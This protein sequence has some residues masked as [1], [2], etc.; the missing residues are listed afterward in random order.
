MRE[1]ELSFDDVF[2]KGLR[3]EVSPVNAPVMAELKNAKPG[4]FGL[5]PYEPIVA[6]SNFSPVVY[7]WPF[8]QYFKHR[9]VELLG[10]RDRLYEYSGGFVT[11][12]HQ[13]DVGSDDVPWE[14]VD[15]DKYQVAAKGTRKLWTRNPVSEVWTYHAAS[16]EIPPCTTVCDVNGQMVVG[17]LQ[18]W[19]SWT[20]LTSSHVAW[21]N[22]GSAVFELDYGN[23]SGFMRPHF[24]GS[25]VM[26][27]QL[28][29]NVIVY[30]HNGIGALFPTMTP[31][32][33]F[34]YR[35][36]ADFGVYDKGSVGGDDKV[37]LIVTLSGVL[38]KLTEEGLTRLGYE[39]FISPM[40][41][42]Y[43]RVSYDPEEKDFYVSNGVT[44]Y[45]VNDY[46]MAEIF[47]RVTSL[48]RV[49]NEVVG[50][51]SDSDDVEFLVVTNEFDMG[52]TA[53]KTTETV[54]VS[55]SGSGTFSVAVDWRMNK[56]DAFQRTEWVELN[57]QGAAAI[58][59]AGVSF[60]LALKSE[61]YEEVK[62][63]YMKLRYKMTDMRSLRGVYAP[64]TSW[65]G[66]Q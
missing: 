33:G 10:M 36:I 20:D 6:P 57:D 24:I 8:P 41:T 15:Y 17:D 60:R 1:F 25:T 61:S 50:V 29:K 2:T 28:G 30:G 38:Y 43:V 19:G 13:L 62:V 44:G 14:V 34:G 48:V 64:P 46:G 35:K 39:E 54:E 7:D 9:Q 56:N 16:T 26:V 31:V 32:P 11:A 58:R 23:L 59:C 55:C 63:G 52:L 37:H 66:Q 5:E 12:A 4:K 65:R 21:S 53:Q 42:D 45:L 22:I 51:A 18:S 27:K 3:Q 49:D 40:Q 47:Q